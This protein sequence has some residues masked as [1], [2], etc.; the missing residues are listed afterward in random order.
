M[1]VFERSLQR[2][3]NGRDGW[4][5]P[6]LIRWGKWGAIVCLLAAS[7]CTR[8]QAAARPTP[9]T[10]ISS[11][12][13]STVQLDSVPA[14][15][16]MNSD[17]AGEVGMLQSLI[18]DPQLKELR[19]MYHGV[20]GASLFFYATSLTYYVALFQ[21]GHLWRVVSTA[22]ETR[23][24]SIFASFA[25]RAR[26][27][28]ANEIGVSVAQ[29]KQQHDAQQIV[30]LEQ[31]MQHLRADLQIEREETEAVRQRQQQAKSQVNELRVQ[32]GQSS[33]KLRLLRK[34]VHVLQRTLEGKSQ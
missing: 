17:V 33:E 25:D 4:M 5:L 18:R 30:I 8:H 19:T 34:N 11:Q 7:G 14:Q 22:N 32:K 20:Y 27:L 9:L 24:E 12:T 6:C 16:Q 3:Q 21:D 1:A 23:A 2:Q 28:A 13:P 10:A 29:A 26:Q 15:S 31:Q